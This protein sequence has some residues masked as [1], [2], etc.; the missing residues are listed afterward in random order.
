MKNG[1]STTDAKALMSLDD[2]LRLEYFDNV[3]ELLARNHP[4]NSSKPGCLTPEKSQK[5]SKLV[6]NY[7]LHELGS[8]LTS[9]NTP[10][11]Q[12]QIPPKTMA[13]VLMSVL[14]NHI[15]PSTAKQLLRITFNGD[16]RSVIDIIIAE[17]MA[18]K[19][20]S[21]KE[22]HHLVR[23]I[24][25]QEP[26]LAEKAKKDWVLGKRSTFMWFVGQVMRKGGKSAEATKAKSVVREILGLVG[27]TPHR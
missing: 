19:P 23:D 20:L 1:L 26:A 7:V 21:E 6:A 3:Y 17:D 22:Y 16:K 18:F 9:T 2:G 15:T 8:L 12:D 24:V 25:S 11:S 27:D 5:L 14:N 4:D 10:F 13:E